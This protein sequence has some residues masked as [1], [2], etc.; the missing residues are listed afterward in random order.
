MASARRAPLRRRLYWAEG[1]LTGVSLVSSLDGAQAAVMG[2]RMK[3]GYALNGIYD[4]GLTEGSSINGVICMTVTRAADTRRFEEAGGAEAP[5]SWNIRTPWGR[6][7]RKPSI[8][9]LLYY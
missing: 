5:E 4:W 1:S 6:G 3:R 2:R 7:D 8:C 9:C